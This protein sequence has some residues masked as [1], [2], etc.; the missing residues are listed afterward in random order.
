MAGL[1]AKL[2]VLLAVLLMPLGM[3]AAPA[4]AASHHS[5]SASMPM[6]HCPEQAPSQDSKRGFVDCTM[7]CSAALPAVE[8]PQEEH[9]P[10]ASTPAAA[11]TAEILHGLHPDTATPPPKLA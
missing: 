7:A 1:M 3:S 10:T 4:A 11:S 6:Q 8:L 9:L 2:L 5:A